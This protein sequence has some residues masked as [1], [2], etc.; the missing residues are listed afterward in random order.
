MVLV[1]EERGGSFGPGSPTRFTWT[2]R[3]IR[4][5]LS[6]CWTLNLISFRTG[7]NFVL[8]SYSFRHSDSEQTSS[9][10]VC[11]VTGDVSGHVIISSG[12]KSSSQSHWVSVCQV[13]RGTWL[14]SSS[15]SPSS[16]SLSAQQVRSKYWSLINSLINTRIILWLFLVVCS[17]DGF[18]YYVTTNCEFNS[19]ELNGIEYTV[20]YNYNKLESS[21]SG[22]AWGSLLD[23]LR[24]GERNAEKWNKGPE[25]VRARAEKEAY[26]L[27]NI[28][29][30][31]KVLW[32]SQVSVCVWYRKVLS[33]EV[34]WVCVCVCVS[35]SVCVCVCVS[36]CVCECQCVCVS[37]VSVCLCVSVFVCVLHV[38]AQIHKEKLVRQSFFLKFQMRLDSFDSIIWKQ[39]INIEGSTQLCVTTCWSHTVTTATNWSFSFFFHEIK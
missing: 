21:R 33:D 7:S 13:S 15:G 18:L 38:P 36:V 32:R 17:S 20:S 22:A 3:K 37:C 16:S 25:V 26:C 1:D 6:R 9:T 39:T 10:L 23:T 2:R 30:E 19:T 27:G 31:Q 5:Q 4:I 11:L 12:F 14:H 34:R 28:R 8:N 29:L 35:S 24:I